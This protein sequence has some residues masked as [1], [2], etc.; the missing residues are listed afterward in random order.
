MTSLGITVYGC[1]PDEA[2]VFNALSPRLGVV[3]TLT[4]TP[5]SDLGA[6]SM[7]G[8]RCIS[9]GHESELPETTLRALRETGV[10]YISTRSLGIDHIDLDAA[11]SLGITVENVVYGPDGVA[12]Y[13]LML[14]LMAVRNA[15]AIVSSAAR[16]DFRLGPVRGKDLRT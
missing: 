3:P 11:E 14:I 5:V 10:E 6:R 8:N 16:N 1:E 7:A 12:D 9:V 4:D 15:K 2:E 13:T